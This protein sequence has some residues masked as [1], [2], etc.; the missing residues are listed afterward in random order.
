M[1]CHS[2]TVSQCHSVTVSQ[3]HRVTVSQCHS[4]TVSHT[5]TLITRPLHIVWFRAADL[6]SDHQPCYPPSD[7][8][9]HSTLRSSALLSSLRRLSSLYSQIISPVILT[10]TVILTLLSDHQPCY[11]HSDGYPHSTL[12]SSALLTSLRRLS[13]LYS[14]IISPVILTQTVILTLL[15]DHQPC[16]PHSDGYPHSTLRSSA[17]L[18]SLRRFVHV[19]RPRE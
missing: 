3:C 12:R 18:T 10:Q 1:T 7:G 13:S 15:S 5:Q 17:L 4:V 6:L 16:Y 19:I 2:V 11:P 8:Y 9:P 14:Q